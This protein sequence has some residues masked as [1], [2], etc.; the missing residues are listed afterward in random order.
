MVNELEGLP[1]S[2]GSNRTLL[3]L[4]PYE[5]L[6]RS[7]AEMFSNVGYYD[8][9]K[10]TPSYENLDFFLQQAKYPPTIKYQRSERFASADCSLADKYT[11][12]WRLERHKL[13]ILCSYEEP[14]R[15]VVSRVR[16]GKLQA[17]LAEVNLAAHFIDRCYLQVPFLQRHT[18]RWR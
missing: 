16:R 13:P 4:R 11:L 9:R 3:W 17:D 18:V 10:Y 6:D 14:V 8:I 12:Q 1:E 5:K 15:V 2:H 7:I